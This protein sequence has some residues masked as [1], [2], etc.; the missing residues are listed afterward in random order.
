MTDTSSVVYVMIMCKHESMASIVDQLNEIEVV[1]EA[2]L[3][4]G[5]WRIV[6]KLQ[7]SAL[8]HLRDAVQWKL[9]KMEG[10]ESTLSLVEYI[11]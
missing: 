6:V 5:P 10:V 4:D 3:V 11:K 7:S 1:K 9:R 8:D 2:T